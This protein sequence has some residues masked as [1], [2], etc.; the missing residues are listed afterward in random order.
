MPTLSPKRQFTQCPCAGVTLDK[1]IQPAVLAVLAEE[2]MHGYELTKRISG[3]P[4]F[5]NEA[6]DISGIYRILKMLEQRGIVA[7]DWEVAKGE[8]AKRVYSITKSGHVCLRH[9][10]KTL[11]QHRQ[12][13]DALLDFT[14]VNKKR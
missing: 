2:P 3:I 14:A 8:R 9:W 13:I 11:Q 4:G 1:L 6:P 7:S 12:A 5:I 10:Q